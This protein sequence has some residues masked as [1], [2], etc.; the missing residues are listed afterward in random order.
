MNVDDADADADSNVDVDV[1][2]DVDNANAIVDSVDED[3]YDDDDS[4]LQF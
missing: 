3:G 1:Y 2:V 4:Y